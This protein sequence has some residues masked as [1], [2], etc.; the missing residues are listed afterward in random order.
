[1]GAVVPGRRDLSES[2]AGEA[3]GAAKTDVKNA[4]RAV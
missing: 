1:V 4:Y 2:S 3:Y